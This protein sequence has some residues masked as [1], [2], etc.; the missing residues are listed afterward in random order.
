MRLHWFT[1]PVYVAT[2]KAGGRYA[3]SNVEK[4]AQYLLSWKDQVAV[5]SWRI[6][7][8]L[9]MA[10]IKDQIP[11]GEARVAFEDAARAAGMLR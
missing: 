1:P 11:A 2:P 5:E 10:A 8:A 6:A 9:C 7:V 4:A 3:V